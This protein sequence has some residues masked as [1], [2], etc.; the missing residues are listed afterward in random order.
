MSSECFLRI[1]WTNVVVILA[2]NILKTLK[3]NPFLMFA[4]CSLLII[5]TNVTRML[6]TNIRITLWINVSGILFANITATV[7]ANVTRMF[8]ENIIVIL[9]TKCY[10][11][12][13]GKYYTNIPN[14]ILL[15][16]SLQILV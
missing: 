12:V 7:W 6:P 8:S 4:E 2:A 11:N 3:R 9:W 13:F 1:L 16:C 10:H 5:S 15:I 14:K